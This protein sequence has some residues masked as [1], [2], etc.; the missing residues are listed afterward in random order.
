MKT[1]TVYL[2]VLARDLCLKSMEPLLP[3]VSAVSIL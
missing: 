3:M 2:L 1:C